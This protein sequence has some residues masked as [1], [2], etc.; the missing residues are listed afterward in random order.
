MQAVSTHP[1]P[2][3]ITIGNFDGVHKG[4]MSLVATALQLA[5]NIAHRQ[6]VFVSQLHA[7]HQETAVKVTEAWQKPMQT[8]II[9]FSP[10][11]ANILG[12]KEYVPLM[13]AAHRQLSLQALLTDAVHVILFD[14]E[15]AQQ[16]GE[17]FCLKLMHEY[18]MRILV[19]GH[20]FRIGHD[21]I[22]KEELIHI[23]EKH[24]FFVYALD[25]KEAVRILNPHTNESTIISSTKI[26]QAIQAGD[27]LLALSMLGKP[28]I[29]QGVVI[30]GHGRGDAILGVPTANIVGNTE[31]VGQSLV[32]PKNGVYA[33][34]CRIL[35]KKYENDTFLSVTNIGNTPTFGG[36]TRSIETHILDFKNDIYGLPLEIAFYN[37]MR[38][39]KAFTHIDD[40]RTQV[41]KDITLRRELRCD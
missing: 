2:S 17:E 30:H 15:L 6:H 31:D 7:M 23:G 4:H 35:N 1:I 32:I 19:I 40:L 14:H 24:G 8:R 12:H 27:T 39:E 21:R 41:H 3:V 11:P 22:G 28:H 37:P 18:T 25:N 13:T 33:T 9:T 34:T 5:H 36:Q 10:H 20:D 16:N 38:T 29:I 26:R